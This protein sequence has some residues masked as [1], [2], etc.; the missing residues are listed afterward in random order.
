MD[1][2][3][4]HVLIAPQE[5]KESLT[6][7]EASNA[8][9]RGIARARPRW[10]LDV[11][12]FS[13]GGPGFLDALEAAHG[14]ERRHA[15]AR[16]TLGRPRRAAYLVLRD[17]PTVA[18]E[19]AQANGLA[20]IAPDE[21]DPLRAST[22]GV[23]DLLAAAA[24]H[25]PARIIVG[26]GGSASTDG[27]TGMARALGARFLDADGNDLP[28]GG[29]ALERLYWIEW[30]RPG[31]F[32]RARVVVASDVTNPLVGP[33]GAAHVFAP[34]KGATP[35]QV[36]R[37]DRA[38]RRFAEVVRESL[39]ARVDRTP[40]G[41]AAG[42]LGAG[43][44]A[45]FGARIVSG[46]DVVAGATGFSERLR[47][48]DLVVTGEGRFDRQSLQGKTTGRVVDA[49]RE[50]GRPVAVFAGTA[51]PAGDVDLHALSELEGN[52]ARSMADAR[53][54]LEELAARWAAGIDP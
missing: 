24:A 39:G 46:F 19:A 37:L 44:V 13:D 20:H 50:A 34:Q 33:G 43:L 16:D 15:D 8:I 9:A 6:A 30:Q 27:G 14:G 4:R 2:P 54:L 7:S 47:Q 18:I 26:V 35:A 31:E 38:L 52:P 36:E 25:A 51:E 21:R 5:F 48:A 28:P 32:D 10:S 53:R 42:G 1:A 22:E 17:G 41:G 3:R 12:P 49:A 45:F 11:V 29:G 23:G 40:G